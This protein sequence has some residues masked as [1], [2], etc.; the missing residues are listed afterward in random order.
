MVDGRLWDS[1]EEDDS[2]EEDLDYLRWELQEKKTLTPETMT[3]LRGVVQMPFK[4]RKNPER[5]DHSG[6]DHDQEILEAAKGNANG[7]KQSG[8]V[9]PSLFA[10]RR[11]NNTDLEKM[12]GLSKEDQQ[13]KMNALAHE[14]S[15]FGRPKEGGAAFVNAAKAP[16]A[17]KIKVSPMKKDKPSENILPPIISPKKRSL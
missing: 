11:L 10:T 1:Q 4:D 13:R 17:E 9:R 5:Y 3:M 15:F 6:S 12:K 8:K 16:S 14:Y 2:S 7:G